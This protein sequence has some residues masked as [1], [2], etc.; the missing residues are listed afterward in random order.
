MSKDPAFLF[1]TGDFSTGTQFF[2][3]EQVGIYLRLLMAQHQHGRLSEKH[4]IIIC[5]S[6]DNDVYSKFRRDNDGLYYN[7]RLEIEI[8]K[9]KSFCESRGKNRS[10]KNNISKSYDNHMENENENKDKDLIK[11][12]KQIVIPEFSEFLE[13]ALTKEPNVKQTSLRLK[14]DAWCEAGW[15][16]GYDKPIRNWKSNLN[17]TLQFIEKNNGN[18]GKQTST[19]A[20]PTYRN[21]FVNAFN[22][23]KQAE[24]GDNQGEFSQDT[25][26]TIVS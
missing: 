26:F 8:F 16:N 19:T 11:L 5:K 20:K 22:L 13:Y 17:N 4:M 18:N 23:A 25:E 15:K 21:T 9:R 1:Y 2:T 14:Y 24:F 10:N 7:E 12:K 3:D 6:Y